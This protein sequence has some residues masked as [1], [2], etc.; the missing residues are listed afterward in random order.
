[1]NDGLFGRL[2]TC[3]A[4]TLVVATAALGL[5]ACG[6]SD[7]D[8][9]RAAVNDFRTA[10]REKDSEAVCQSFTDKALEDAFRQKGDEARK[11][12]ADFIKQSADQRAKEAEKDFEITEVKVDGDKASVKTKSE[13]QESQAK[14]EKVD[15]EWKIA[16]SG[17]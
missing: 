6:G 12:C 1:M 5:A 4:G 11:R 3:T 8:D 17:G 15:E 16:D 10:V 13:G 14:L 9:V 7:E 2:A